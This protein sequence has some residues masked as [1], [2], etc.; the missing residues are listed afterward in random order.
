VRAPRAAT[1]AGSDQQRSLLDEAGS[2]GL[3][4]Q[5]RRGAD[6]LKVAQITPARAW[7]VAP[8]SA[9]RA[10]QALSCTADHCWGISAASYLADSSPAHSDPARKACDYRIAGRTSA[11]MMSRV[12]SSA[13]RREYRCAS[14]K[15]G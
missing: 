10:Q 6:D 9:A 11:A 2:L 5:R 4:R 1:R 3:G 14:D 12:V 13:R 7:P 15:I 8:G